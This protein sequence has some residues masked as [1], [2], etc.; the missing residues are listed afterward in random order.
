MTLPAEVRRR[1]GI[2]KGDLVAVTETAEG[3]LITP[4]ELITRREIA[5]LDQ[6]LKSSGL[7]FEQLIE[8]G[9]EIRGELIKE[10]YGLTDDKQN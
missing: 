5:E 10:A 1:L 7:T 3:I 2:K 8:S 9:R 4:S 6:V